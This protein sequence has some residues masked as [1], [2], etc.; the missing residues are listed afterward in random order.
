MIWEQLDENLIF[1]ELEANNNSD[2]MQ[3][4]G[5][6]FIKEGVCKD[7]YIK[8]LIEREEEYPTGLNIDGFGVA[9]P[10]TSVEHVN[11]AKIAI[12]TLKNKVDF[13]HMGTDNENVEVDLVVMLAVDNPKKHLST[14][15]GMLEILQ[16]KE[17]LYKMTQ[18]K[19]KEDIIQIIKN[20][21]A[22]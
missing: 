19:Q 20:K 10:H 17:V 22:M 9:I 18:V 13:I 11:E 3:K 12:A 1:V 5:E 6:T 2:V 21:E 14:L 7:T 4:M 16:D 8:A 15:Q